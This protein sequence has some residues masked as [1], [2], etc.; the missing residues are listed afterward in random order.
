VQGS[1]LH[2]K[3]RQDHPGALDG[4][5]KQDRIKF[6]TLQSSCWVGD[7]TLEPVAACASALLL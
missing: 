7:S 3:A 2:G 4:D 1:A 5:A 6:L